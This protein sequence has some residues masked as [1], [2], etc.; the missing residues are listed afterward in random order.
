MKCYFIE[1]VQNVIN[2]SMVSISDMKLSDFR[3][4]VYNKQKCDYVLCT[5][6]CSVLLAGES[7]DPQPITHQRNIIESGLVQ[8][9][10]TTPSRSTGNGSDIK[11]DEEYQE[12]VHFLRLFLPNVE[13]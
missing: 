2:L 6:S 13:A 10:V 9:P 12:F 11:P 8:D 7:G 1:D 3:E 5:L 4:R